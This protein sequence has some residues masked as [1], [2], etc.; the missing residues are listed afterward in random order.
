MAAIHGIRVSPKF[1]A[2]LRPAITPPAT[3][4][5]ATTARVTP[6]MRF[7]GMSMERGLKA[8][9]ASSAAP[10]RSLATSVSTVNGSRLTSLRPMVDSGS[11]K[12]GVTILPR[13]STISAPAGMSMRGAD[14]H[15]PAVPDE[16]GAVGNAAGGG[17]SL[18][19]AADDGERAGV[20]RRRAG[21][22]GRR[23]QA[24]Q[25]RCAHQW[26]PP[27]S[28]MPSSKSDFGWRSGSCRS[29]TSAPSI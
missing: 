26:P 11:M 20:H 12:P 17:R 4:T 13:A 10:K 21:E 15:D 3:P 1:T 7:T 5:G 28:I 25:E 29:Y 2:A 8:S 18:D 19:G 14:G 24:E 22:H 9:A 23:Q 6:S 16:H 27:I